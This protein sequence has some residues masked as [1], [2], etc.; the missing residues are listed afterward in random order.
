MSIPRFSALPLVAAFLLVQAASV[1]AAEPAADPLPSWNDGPARKAILQFVRDTTDKESKKYVR[2][3]E[4]LATFDQDGTLWVEQPIYTQVAFALE[5]VAVLAPEHPEWKTREPFKAILAGDREAMAKFTI[6]EI[7]EIVAV[8]HSG[9][10]VE[11]FREIVKDWLARAKHPRFKRPYTELV[12]QPML[13]VMKHLRDN[14]YK[15]YVVTGGGQDF[16]RVYAE[17]V[18]GIPPEQVIGSAGQTKYEYGKDGKP[19]LVK[20]PKALLIDDKGG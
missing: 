1:P 14:G 10:T 13:E 7:E 12:Y 18:Y 4:R 19:V 16:V 3:A 5:R 15:T 11:A 8:T 9:I 2:P 20:L 6:Q 17:A